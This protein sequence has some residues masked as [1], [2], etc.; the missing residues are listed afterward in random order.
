[1]SGWAWAGIVV[2][3]LVGVPVGIGIVEAAVDKRWP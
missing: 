1:M 3:V 2:S